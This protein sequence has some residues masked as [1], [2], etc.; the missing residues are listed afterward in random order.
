MTEQNH[1]SPMKATPEEPREESPELK[2][3]LTEME[4][5][6]DRRMSQVIHMYNRNEKSRERVLRENQVKE[7]TGSFRNE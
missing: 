7:G 2:N 6:E 1:K 3:Y 5:I 4:P